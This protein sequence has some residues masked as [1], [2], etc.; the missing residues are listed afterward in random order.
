MRGI[1]KEGHLKKRVYEIIEKAKEGDIASRIFDYSIL[2]L[3]SLTVISIIIESYNNLSLTY[4][5]QLW[6]FEIFSIII[7]TIEYGLRIWT[8]DEMFPEL[9]KKQARKKYVFSFMAIIDLLAI[10]P[11][12]LPMI[13]PFDLRF[14]R[15]IR[16]TRFLRIFKLNRYSKALGLIGKIIK[17]K[18]EELLA[19]IFIM[20]FIIMISSTLI[21]YMESEIQPESFPNI[22][23]SF[24]WAIATLT[25][26]GYG[27]VY[28]VTG[29]G[30]IL[31]SII[32]ISGIG[33]VALPTG[34]LSSG[35]MEE[36]SNKDSSHECPH[37]GKKIS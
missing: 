31:A 5:K 32:A 2:G 8:S 21:Y 25:T 12:Y 7:F 19:T 30:K 34:I 35:F 27:D 33:L 4:S 3:I 29:F 10:L 9:S 37:C 28:P 24:W 15:I 1:L 13:L 23:D 22:V 6:Y 17:E 18:K 36:L 11:F 16:L 14:L 26:V 20:L